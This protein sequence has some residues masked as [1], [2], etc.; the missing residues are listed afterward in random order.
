MS[1][2]LDAEQLWQ[3]DTCV[4]VLAEG[5]DEVHFAKRPGGPCYDSAVIGGKAAMP[6]VLMQTAGAVYAWAYVLN[7]AGRSRRCWKPTR[8]RTNGPAS[9]GPSYARDGLGIMFTDERRD[10]W[11]TMGTITLSGR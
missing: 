2:T 9:A 7:G 8:I 6:D 11:P 5:C 4:Q 3:W 1:I 10:A